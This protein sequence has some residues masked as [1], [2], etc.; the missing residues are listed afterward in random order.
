[1]VGVKLLASWLAAL[2]AVACV[3]AQNDTTSSSSA[4]VSAA[5]EAPVASI[6]SVSSTSASNWKFSPVTLVQARVQGN[7]PVWDAE[8]KVY[9]SS[10]GSSFEAKYLGVLDTV[11]TAAVE[12][13]F[14]YVQAECINTDAV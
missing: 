9:I 1:M 3:S 12:G 2:S 13:A 14:K 5:T 11:N 7:L 8:H 6:S 4:T 10:F